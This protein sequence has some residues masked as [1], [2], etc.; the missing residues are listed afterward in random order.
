VP[1]GP[2]DLFIVGDA[3]QRIHGNTA[4]LRSVGIE[5]RGRS[6]RLRRNYRSTHQII[7][8]ALGVIGRESVFDIDDHGTDLR[9]YHSVRTGPAPEVHEAANRDAELERLAQL[10]RGWMSEGYCAHDIAIVARTEREVEELLCHLAKSGIQ[11]AAITADGRQTQAVNV[12]TMHRV[13][14]LEFAC[15]AVSGLASTSIPLADAICPADVDPAQHRADMETERALIYVSAT[16]ARDQ[17]ALTWSG[18]ASSL[19]PA[20]TQKDRDE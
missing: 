3:F 10:A 13:K 12:A 19:L 15:V 7:G 9:G 16:R 14:G 17:L 8:W 1:P 11:A 4:S 18:S 6:V 2:D 5:T 20:T